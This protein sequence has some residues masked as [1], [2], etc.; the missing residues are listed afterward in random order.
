MNRIPALCAI[1]LVC[2][3][4]GAPSGTTHATVPVVQPA[5]I[6]LVPAP[7]TPASDDGFDVVI[8]NGR[9]LD[10]MGNPWIRADVGIRNGR[11]AKI[12]VIAERG[13]SEIDAAGKYVSPGWIDMMDQSGAVLPRNGLAENKLRM[14]VTTAIGGE[15]G[16]PVRGVAQVGPYFDTLAA[17]G[18]SINF[19]SY[20]SATQ[21][22]SA[23]L[24]SSARAPNAASWHACGPS[25]TARC[26]AARWE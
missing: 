22:R 2:A 20:Y 13:R 10:G 6:T 23:V 19:G 4:A 1:A 24:G 8:R 9:V 17:R 25:W 7:A 16:V 18:I 11:F 26:V 3:C 15:A 5:T 14:G 21:A 12:G